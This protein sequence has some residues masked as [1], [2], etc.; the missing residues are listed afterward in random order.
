MNGFVLTYVL[1]DRTFIY[2]LKEYKW[3]EYD[4]KNTEE[5]KRLK[6]LYKITESISLDTINIAVSRMNHPWF[7]LETPMYTTKLYIEPIE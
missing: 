3:I 4:R 2:S 5:E 7:G 1:S 6:Q